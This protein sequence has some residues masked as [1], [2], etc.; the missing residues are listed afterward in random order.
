V[1]HTDG[2]WGHLGNGFVLG[3]VALVV[4]GLAPLVTGVG[5]G[6]VGHAHVHV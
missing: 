5:L 3:A 1:G 2:H 6:V 4:G